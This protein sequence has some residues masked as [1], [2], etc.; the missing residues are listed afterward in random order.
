M[1]VGMYVGGPVD[2]RY[3]A[4]VEAS[5]RAQEEKIRRAAAIQRETGA[6][7][8]EDPNSSSVTYRSGAGG[9]SGSSSSSAGGGSG[10]GNVDF[11]GALSSIPKYPGA[12]IQAPNE[13]DDPNLMAQAYGRAKDLA[14]LESQGAAKSI[15]S[16]MARRGLGGSRFAVSQEAGAVKHGLNRLGQYNLAEAQNRAKRGMEINDRNYQGGI[17]QRGQDVSAQGNRVSQAI[18]LAALRARQ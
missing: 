11:A 18:S 8:V 10:T 5:R 3:M 6:E 4:Q 1:A 2:P 7:W 16:L 15:R 9:G 14:G 12:Y 17:A 13:T